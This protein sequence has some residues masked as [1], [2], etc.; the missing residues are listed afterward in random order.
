[1]A[2]CGADL[3]RCQRGADVGLVGR[4]VVA[5]GKDDVG[6]ISRER[7][8]ADPDAAVADV[9]GNLRRGDRQRTCRQ[10]RFDDLPQPR[11]VGR[12]TGIA[13]ADRDVERTRIE[14]WKV[15]P[16]ERHGAAAG[17]RA[18]QRRSAAALRQQ[19][20]LHCGT[21]L[22]HRETAIAQGRSVDAR[23][24]HICI[25]GESIDALSRIDR[26]ARLAAADLALDAVEGQGLPVRPDGA[27]DRLQ[28]GAARQQTV[29]RF[30][31]DPAAPGARQ[32]LA[33]R[34]RR[35]VPGCA[36]R[37]NEDRRERDLIEADFTID[38]FLIAER[39]RQSAAQPRTRDDAVEI[40]EGQFVARER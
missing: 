31:R 5:A 19:R 38:A 26:S 16:I 35:I 3:R 6:T 15:Q 28:L 4:N 17:Q 34:L 18:D 32:P 30:E 21:P 24:L 1:M 7:G 11:I 10:R 29:Q 22:G 27:A 37:S 23:E 9:E 39:Q 13:G 33:E 36:D 12:L 25:Q 20:H 2:V 40:V 14:A 8:G